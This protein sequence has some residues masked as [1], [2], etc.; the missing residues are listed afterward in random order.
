MMTVSPRRLA[1]LEGELAAWQA[2][3]LIADREAQAIRAR[4]VPSR[5]FSLARLLLALGAA[6]VSVGLIWLVAANLDRISPLMRFIAVTALWLGLVVAAEA[7]AE[8]RTRES[9]QAWPVVGA[10]RMLAAAGFGAVIF[11]AAQSLQVPAYSAA[12]VGWWSLGAL[13]YAYA[14]NGMAPLVVGVLTGTVWFTWQSAAQA[15]AFSAFVGAV[16]LGAVVATAAGVVHAARWRPGFATSWRLAGALLALLGMFTAALPVEDAP[17]RPPVAVVV[18]AVVA[19]LAAGAALVLGRAPD[20]FEVVV[21]VLAAAV[22]TALVA[23][24]PDGPVDDPSPAM[25]TRA[26]LSVLV[27]LLL[28]AWYAVLGVR[29]DLPGVTGL[30]TAALV[31]FTTVQSFAVFA[32]I[33]S[34]ATLFLV[35]GAVL[36][37]S[38]YGF[39]RARR[40][41]VASVA[42][43][44]ENPAHEAEQDGKEDRP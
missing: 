15:Q 19:V 4:Y 2:E 39:D 23:W 9:D 26:V 21:P 29:S 37:G 16:L 20:R 41:L 27:Y 18:G 36:L 30:A 6:F 34:G 33:I 11:Q 12:L 22:G 31:L 5:R 17:A 43:D 14:V 28:A 40:T 1:W 35:V 38:G 42:E 13:L 24:H 3:G 7:L 8:R 25:T 10:V 44:A 32:R